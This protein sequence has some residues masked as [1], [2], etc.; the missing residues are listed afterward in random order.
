MIN[1]T[2][3]TDSFN[4]GNPQ[5]N[6]QHIKQILTPE[7]NKKL[8]K[9]DDLNKKNDAV[10]K[11]VYE[12]KDANKSQLEP[13][14]D[15]NSLALS[16]F[17]CSKIDKSYINSN[18]LVNQLFK[19]QPNQNYQPLRRCSSL[20]Y[21]VFKAVNKYDRK[22][23]KNNLKNLSEY[24]KSSRKR[25]SAY[26]VANDLIIE[27]LSNNLYNGSADQLLYAAELLEEFSE[28]VV[29]VPSLSSQLAGLLS[30]Q[31]YQ[32]HNLNN[33]LLLI[34]HYMD[35]LKNEQEQEELLT[36]QLIEQQ[37]VNRMMIEINKE[38]ELNQLN[39]ET[40]CDKNLEISEET[41]VK[42]DQIGEKIIANNKTPSLINKKTPTAIKKDP[43]MLSVN[44]HESTQSEGDIHSDTS[45]GKVTVKC[46]P[47]NRFQESQFEPTSQT[48]TLTTAKRQKDVSSS[49]LSLSSSS[50]T[51][52]GDKD[53]E[54]EFKKHKQSLEHL[55]H[56]NFK[57]SN[58][59]SLNRNVKHRQRTCCLNKQNANDNYCLMYSQSSNCL[60]EHC[61]HQ[62]HEESSSSS[63]S[64]STRSTEDLNWSSTVNKHRFAGC[65]QSIGLNKFNLNSHQAHQNS[66]SLYHSNYL[67]TIISSS[68]CSTD[69]SCSVD[70]PMRHN[71]HKSAHSLHLHHHH[72][73]HSNSFNSLN[74][75]SDNNLVCAC[76]EQHQTNSHLFKSG[77]I[78]NSSAYL[79]DLNA[80]AFEPGKQNYNY[81]NQKASN[82]FDY[83]SLQI[84]D[85]INSG[86][87]LNFYYLVGCFSRV[88]MLKRMILI[89]YFYCM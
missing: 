63:S 12:K 22:K 47:T 46:M 39:Q 56:G 33:Q 67:N 89:I 17:A 74:A 69:D 18:R 30:P 50:K 87:L 29:A 51:L 42:T 44:G 37:Q 45:D 54:K 76:C 24:S 62:H 84:E 82:L 19:T 35:C 75:V 4:S 6:E 58:Y 70:S 48:S 68:E 14:A 2:A 40:S 61:H 7:K 34:N 27:T 38:Q 55:D 80:Y 57:S 79:N 16:P 9:P 1:N 71:P 10:D 20:P 31:H 59:C 13:N 15:Q 77:Q 32:K 85:M 26:N 60:N 66:H 28:N 53:Q 3:F 43:A 41:D 86:M 8:K 64:Q 52:L 49:G 5:Q 73:P 36:V 81:S 72:Q 11:N 23:E 78:P 83:P 25:T 21:F 65:A 88:K